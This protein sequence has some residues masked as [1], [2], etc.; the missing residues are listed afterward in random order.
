MFAECMLFLGGAKVASDAVK[1]EYLKS[2]QLE[3]TDSEKQEFLEDDTRR[4][5][6][7]TSKENAKKIM[8]S[9]FLIPTKGV[10]K[11]HFT[12]SITKDG[13]TKN[14]DMVYMFDT[15][16]FSVDDYIRNL[17]KSYSPFNGVYEYYA[18]STKPDEYLV[19]GFKKRAQDGAI[20]YEGR[21][22]IDGTDTKLTKYVLTLDENEKYAFKEMALDEEYTPSDTLLSHL[23]KDKKSR[24][25]YDIRN[26]MS[27]LKKAK[28][29]IKSF[30]INKDE[31]KRQIREKREFAKASKQFM[32]EE[33]EKSYTYKK[34]GRCIVVKNMSYDM[35][36]G[37]KLQKLAIMENVSGKKIEDVTKTCYMDEC[38]LEDLD[39]RV[40]TEYF[41]NNLDNISFN[42]Q[43]PDYIGLPEENLE[44]GI[45]QND[46]DEKFKKSY[47]K[48]V[49]AKEYADKKQSEYSQNKLKNKIKSFFNKVFKRNT[50]KML[51]SGKDNIEKEEDIARKKLNDLGYSSVEAMNKDDK[52]ITILD[53]LSNMT[54]TDYEFMKND[55]NINYT[56]NI[57]MEDKEI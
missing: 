4:F 27:E 25:G 36:D 11:N 37:K 31:Y 35:V 12:K 17:P 21:L 51:D 52:N 38:N 34:D 41:F 13:K 39:S 19:N 44:K 22:D 48:R 43:N 32:E 14:S 15:K 42:T 57:Q 53:N 24:L 3:L 2:K 8:N 29:S 23:N 50:V 26:Y 20:T 6:H 49:K 9:G 28:S 40:A 16:T 1:I 5:I 33:K 55:E 54:Y 56:R 30:R 47:E 7:F 45:I 10:L 46:Y 18:V